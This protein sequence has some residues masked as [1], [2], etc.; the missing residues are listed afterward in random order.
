[1]AWSFLVQALAPDRLKENHASELQVALK[2]MEKE[3][4]SS[5]N[6]IRRLKAALNDVRGNTTFCFL[7]IHSTSLPK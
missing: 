3:L 4:E 2:S 1:L 6:Q 5:R 7:H